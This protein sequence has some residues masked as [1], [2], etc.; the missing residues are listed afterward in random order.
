LEAGAHMVEVDVQITRDDRAVV[1]HD[2][3]LGRT[4]NGSGRIRNFSFEELQNLDAGSWFSEQFS[5][6]KIPALREA[7]S[8]L[9]GRAYVNI[10][11]KPPQPDEDYADRTEKIVQHV[12][13][14]GMEHHTLF[15]SFH[16]ASL[17]SLKQKFPE[18]H[19]AA[20]Q[21]PGDNRLPSEIAADIGCE[22]FVCS[23]REITH[24]RAKDAV[25]HGIYVGVYVINTQED[26]QK[27]L[28]YD[29]KAIVTNFPGLIINLLA[30]EKISL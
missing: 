24:R 13:E 2:S 20:I 30:K 15:S 16:H 3:V 25:D 4:T 11:I 29:I 5:G 8:M 12:Y 22:G 6:E 7:L 9:R 26:L 14:A 19:T 28:Q 27:L 18:L 17:K 23:L 10:E 21:V 1:F